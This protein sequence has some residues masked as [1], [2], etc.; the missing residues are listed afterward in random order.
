M[1]ERIRTDH[2]PYDLWEQQG[3]LTVTEGDVIDYTVIE[4]TILEINK[5]FHIIELDSDRAMA[6]M[7]LQRLEKAGI[8]CVDIPQTFASLTDP[9]NQIEILLKGKKPIEPD[10]EQ[11]DTMPLREEI[12]MLTGKPLTGRLTHENNPVARWCFGNTSVAK[13]GQGYIKFVKEHKGQSVSRTK[14]IDLISA[15]VD[16]MARARFYTGSVDLSAEILSDDWGM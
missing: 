9:M 16:S 15:L 10:P 5:F 14:R 8:T 6:T 13:N 7:L 2:I 1:Q 3:W 12:K 4:E 11:S